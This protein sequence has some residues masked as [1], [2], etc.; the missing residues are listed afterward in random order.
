MASEWRPGCWGLPSLL[1]L[2]KAP[3]KNSQDFRVALTNK[4]Q[5]GRRQRRREQIYNEKKIK[6]TSV[7]AWLT[8]F[9]VN[10]LKKH[11]GQSQSLDEGGLSTSSLVIGACLIVALLWVAPLSQAACKAAADWLKHFLSNYLCSVLAGAAWRAKE[12]TGREWWV[13]ARPRSQNITFEP[14]V[15]LQITTQGW[16]RV[17]MW[18]INSFL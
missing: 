12:S 9:Y 1:L 16:I 17:F 6:L 11:G 18:G 8:L 15:L 3:L 7:D 10:T 4:Q 13:R 2:Q 5:E 14:H